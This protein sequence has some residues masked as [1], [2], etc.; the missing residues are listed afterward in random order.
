MLY[1]FSGSLSGSYPYK[2]TEE[3]HF[4]KLYKTKRKIFQHI[5]AKDVCLGTMPAIKKKF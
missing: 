5:I 3:N 4:F 2:P 1:T